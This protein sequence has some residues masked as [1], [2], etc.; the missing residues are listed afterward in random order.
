MKDVRTANELFG[1]WAAIPTPWDR[2]GRLDEGMLQRNV[3]R[4]ASVPCDGIYSTDSD[5]EFYAFEL[6]DF[7]HFVQLFSRSM[8]PTDCAIQVGV[9]W[10]N[11]QGIIDRMNVCLDHGISTVHIC[12]PY[13]MP[14]N[15]S[16][17]KH[18][19]H[20]LAAA[21]PD[22]RWVH[23]NTPRGHVPMEGKHYRWLA[24][25]F[26][27]QFIGTKLGTQ[28]F[29]HLS[30]IIGSTPQIAHVLTDYTVVP[31][32]MLGGRG[33][34][35]FWVNTLPDW[36][37]RLIDLC[38][39]KQWDEAMSMQ[40]KLNGWEFECIEPLVREGY[41]HGIVGKARG[42]VTN[43]LEDS[44]HTRA[45]YQP[46]PAEKAQRL[47]EQFQQGWHEEIAEASMHDSV[48]S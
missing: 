24:A 12:Y 1:L 3:E 33:A 22:A 39:E 25:E 11:T 37:R 23:Y 14:L 6:E 20:D 29:L 13:W 30:D 18:F 7:C 36:Q 34:Y 17:V 35:S 40:L 41:L 10:T 38:F 2:Q 43:F 28:N 26:P 47:T 19:W 5:G 9:T 46:V 4:L 45:P 27:E 8:S 32:M 31:G 15:E 48:H 16:D 44:G 21:V 42:A